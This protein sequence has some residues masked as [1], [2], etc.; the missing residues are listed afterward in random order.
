MMKYIVMTAMLACIGY[1]Q[2]APVG[3]EFTYQGELRQSGEK[4]EGVFDFE[5][6][7]FNDGAAGAELAVSQLI[8]NLLVTNGLFN[9]TLDFGDTVFSGDQVWI[10][11]SVRVGASTSAYTVLQPR[12]AIRPSPYAMH[13]SSVAMDAITSTEIAND[14]IGSSEISANA[15]GSSE[16]IPNA[17]GV[18][19]INDL[20]V[21]RRISQ[22]CLD[23]ESIQSIAQNGTVS[24]IKVSDPASLMNQH[25]LDS[26]PNTGLWPDMVFGKDGNPRISYFDADEGDLKLAVCDDPHCN[27][28]QIRILDSGGITGSYTS[29]AMPADGR[30]V[31]AYYNQSQTSLQYARCND[32]LCTSATITTLDNSGSVGKYSS[33]AFRGSTVYISYYDEGG[34][35]LKLLVCLNSLSCNNP[36]II[37]VDSAGD[38]GRYSAVFTAPISDRTFLAY[39]DASNGDLKGVTCRL[40]G[41]NLVCESPIILDSTGAAVGRYVRGTINNLGFPVIFYASGD[42][43]TVQ[44]IRGLYCTAG[45][46]FNNCSSYQTRQI[47]GVCGGSCLPFVLDVTLSDQDDVYV[48][49]Q[50]G[51]MHICPNGFCDRV[52]AR[53]LTGGTTAGNEEYGT[54]LLV[55]K[56]G[57]P[58]IAGRIVG[59]RFGVRSCIDR[60]CRNVSI[61]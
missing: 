13:A 40:N 34:T 8:D 49:T 45:S 38:V 10:E 57:L 25:L 21:Q 14:A 47:S 27:T 54:A 29:I 28:A 15:V 53:I 56:D 2:A 7:V 51:F 43:N 55:G 48:R 9:A 44:S 36:T 37:V 23:G 33:I 35:Q 41:I 61:P 46:V 52:S 5:F 20:E 24:C 58:I 26:N 30:A 1:L 42:P 11:V 19:E 3:T 4:A 18:S 39:Y 12:H 60:F 59:T 31:I 16:I 17:V 50:S 32:P 22:V 6:R